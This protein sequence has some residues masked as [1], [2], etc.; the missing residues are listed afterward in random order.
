[1][2]DNGEKIAELMVRASSALHAISEMQDASE[3]EKQQAK[4]AYK[5][6]LRLI[7]KHSITSYEGRTAALTG[8]VVELREIT[9]QIAV[10]S[11]IKTHIMQI[12][13]IADQA[14]VFFKQEKSADSA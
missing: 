7:A 6:V 1:M 2:P 14:T 8:L 5:D 13:A 11:P 12:S 4:Q 10:N 3:V 9:S